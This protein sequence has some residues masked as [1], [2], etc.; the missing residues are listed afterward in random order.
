MPIIASSTTTASWYDGPT[1]W[2]ATMKSP[3]QTNGVALGATQAR[4]S[5]HSIDPGGTRNRQAKGRPPSGYRRRPRND[6]SMCRGSS[7]P[8]P[9][10]CGGIGRAGDIRPGWQGAGIDPLLRGSQVGPAATPRTGGSVRTEHKVRSGRRFPAP[11]PSPGRASGD[12]RGFP[13]WPRCGPWTRPGHSIRSTT[14]PPAVPGRPA[15]RSGRYVHGRDAK[16][17]VGDGAQATLGP[18]GSNPPIVAWPAFHTVRAPWAGGSSCGPVGWDRGL[19]ERRRRTSMSSPRV[20]LSRPARPAAEFGISR[21]ARRR[22]VPWIP[23]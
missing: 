22:S 1:L 19:M 10:E 14:T 8:P 4:R 9:P 12:R 5:C 3:P 17:P 15:R 2:R 20:I 18:D 13:A 7:A 21:T 6:A 23:N 11:R 16:P